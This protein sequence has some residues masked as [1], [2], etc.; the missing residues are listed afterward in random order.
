MA[1]SPHKQNLVSGQLLHPSLF[2][3]FSATRFGPS[4]ARMTA[5]VGTDEMSTCRLKF[6]IQHERH[7]HFRHLRLFVHAI[8]G[9]HFVQPVHLVSGLDAISHSSCSRSAAFE[10]FRIVQAQLGLS[11]QVHN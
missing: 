1:A 6:V 4:T 2:H 9:Q 11:Q 3:I 7:P 8:G 5:G 10:R